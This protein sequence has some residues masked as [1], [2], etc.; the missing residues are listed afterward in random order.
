MVVLLLIVQLFLALYCVFLCFNFER[1]A[2]G[3][4]I[5][6]FALVQLYMLRMCFVYGRTIRV[7][8]DGCTVKFLV[9]KKFYSWS[10]LK[11]KRI[12]DYRQRLGKYDSY[13]KGVVFSK[14]ANFHTPES[15]T[16]SLYLQFCLN[17]FRFFFVL[18]K[19]TAKNEFKCYE[20]DEQDF[21]DK[22]KEYGVVL[23]GKD[24]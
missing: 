5:L 24:F 4:I 2:I 23:D 1:V 21:M 12:E 19:P 17:P 16:L 6:I 15:L 3:V 11:T 9:F 20:V 13:K 10:E 8:A 14:K 7:D 22:M 18:F